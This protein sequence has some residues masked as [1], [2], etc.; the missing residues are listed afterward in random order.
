MILKLNFQIFNV[1]DVYYNG[2]ITVEITGVV[3]EMATVVLVTVLKKNLLIVP[4]YE[5][6]VML[7]QQLLQLQQHQQ[8]LPVQQPAQQQA[9]YQ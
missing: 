8:L 9:Q 2:F 5:S 3:M 4:M 7:Q 6:R 1:I